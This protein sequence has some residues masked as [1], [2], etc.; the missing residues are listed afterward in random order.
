M[1]IVHTITVDSETKEVVVETSLDGVVVETFL[2]DDF[3]INHS[4]S[5]DYEKD[6]DGKVIS[7]VPSGPEEMHF[8]LTKEKP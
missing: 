2:A 7:I 5:V 3:R 6:A 4:R 1:R 8:I